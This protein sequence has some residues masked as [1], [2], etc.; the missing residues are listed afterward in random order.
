[1]A[2]RQISKENIVAALKEVSP[3]AQEEG[4]TL[5]LEPLN[6]LVDHGGYFL[7]SSKEAVEIIGEMDSPVLRLLYD[8]YHQQI[9]EG[10]LINNIT[11]HIDFVE[12]TR[13]ADV[14]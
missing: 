13:I 14:P 12:H 7:S 9:T 1:M 8:V 3:I 5:M 10:N 11:N 4:I 2:E 6:T